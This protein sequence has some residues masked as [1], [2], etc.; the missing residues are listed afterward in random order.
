MGKPG[1]EC[2]D[3]DG[4]DEADRLEGAM[5]QG[6]QRGARQEAGPQQEIRHPAEAFAAKA[7]IT[8]R[9]IADEEILDRLLLPMINEDS[10]LLKLIFL[11]Q[12][13][14][15]AFISLIRSKEMKFG[16]IK[17]PS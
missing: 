5:R 14:E 15:S 2:S 12:V 1:K 11:F 10:L 3:G 8:R 9:E 4:R 6:A 17:T 7:G 13:D 16:R